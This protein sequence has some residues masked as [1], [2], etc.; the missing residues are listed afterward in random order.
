MPCFYSDC[1]D[2][3]AN[4]RGTGIHTLLLEILF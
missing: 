2:V 4:I 3:I 1:S